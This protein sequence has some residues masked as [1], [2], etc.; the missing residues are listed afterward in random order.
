MED[1]FKLTSSLLDAWKAQNHAR[2]AALLRKVPK[3]FVACVVHP[4]AMHPVVMVIRVR[5]S[6]DAREIHN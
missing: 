2:Y 1:I 4:H 3:D 5:A 6:G